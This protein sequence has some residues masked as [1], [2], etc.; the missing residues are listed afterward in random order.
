M[1]FKDAKGMMSDIEQAK[2]RIKEIAGRNPWLIDACQKEISKE[3]GRA[4]NV[5]RGLTLTGPLN[6]DAI[7]STS[8]DINVCLNMI[9]VSPGVV[10]NDKAW[11]RTSKAILRYVAGNDKLFAF[12]EFI[13][14]RSKSGQFQKEFEDWLA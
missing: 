13:S 2:G 4:F 6:A 11:I 10:F 1:S 12:E 9:S 14:G 7:V 8:L 3:F 5:Y